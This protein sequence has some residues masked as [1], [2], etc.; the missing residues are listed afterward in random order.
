MGNIEPGNNRFY[1]S[2]K[3]IAIVTLFIL[4]ASILVVLTNFSINMIAAS[5]DYTALLS[6]WSQ[7]HY[8]TG[9]PIERYANTGNPSAYRDYLQLK[10][11][12]EQL[13][14]PINELFKEEV[15]AN[16]I[17]K[18]LR[19]DD[20]LHNEI[21]TLVLAFS[22]FH[23]LDIVQK[24]SQEWQRL[25]EIQTNQETLVEQ[26]H[27]ERGAGA[28]DQEY[29]NQLVSDIHELNTQWDN[30]NASLM[31]SMEAASLS[32]KRIG[33]WISVILG[34]LLVLIG[35]VVSVRAG[36]SIRRWEQALHE[37]EILLSEIHHRVKNNLAVISGLLEME[38]MQTPDPEQALKESRDRIHSMAMIHEILYQ[39]Q[40]FSEIRL[41]HYINKLSD[42]I[43][44][45][46]ARSD[47]QI[48]L[49]ANLEPV[50]LNINQAVPTGLIL[51]ELMAN[52]IEHGL[53]EQ[54][55]GSITIHLDE[56]EGK[57]RLVL[58]DNGKALPPDFELETADTTGLTIVKALVKQLDGRL[59][60]NNA[61]P[62]TIELEFS[63]SD[64]SGSSNR[65]F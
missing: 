31:D 51:N 33:L 65:Y 41:D 36:K 24:L 52:A 3:L 42:H 2:R 1:L 22:L 62:S 19:A 14:R 30:R 48:D 61:A 4:I 60:I 53:K 43:C 8:K 34:I 35:V 56:S 21:S 29:I 47:K 13:G 50:T 59:S 58:Q 57:V 7:L 37:K 64:A 32:I 28:Q 12:M 49:H 23:D 45:T 10:N 63:K 18:S 27:S 6:K 9:I 40:S 26:L 39:S 11:E 15:Y 44:D 54:M 38:S 20:V 55:Q 5:R 17:F 46:Y 16:L 25:Q